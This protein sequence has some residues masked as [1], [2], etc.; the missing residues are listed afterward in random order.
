MVSRPAFDA[1][2]FVGRI[3]PK[4]WNRLL[5]D[6]D[7]PL[8]NRAIQA[9]LA[10]GSTF[11]PILALAA[12]ELGAIDEN[13]TVNC[14][15]SAM[16]YG[17]PFKCHK[18]HGATSLHKAI[19]QSCD[20]FFYA[21]G[22]KVGIDGIAK[23]GEMAG[24]GRKTG[25]DLPQEKEGELPSSSWKIRKFREKWYAG[26]TISVAIGQG[27]LTLTPI[28]LAQAI[29]GIATGGIWMKPHLV[30]DTAPT[31]PSRREDLNLDNV[32]KVVSGMYGVVNEWGTAAA[33][34]IPSISICGKT[35]TSQTAS[36]DYIKAMRAKG[37]SIKDNAW[38]VSFAPR[39]SPEIVVAVL[40]EEGLHGNL[41]APIAR[42]VIKAYF[43]KK[44]RKAAP[45]SIAN[46]FGFRP[47]AGPLR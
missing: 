22:N 13:F 7:K 42:D 12:L 4:E 6:P 8:I 35:G 25:I 24:L 29:G 47:P 32:S 39:E 43:D 21:V 3:D 40:F 44:V 1:N 28:Q 41:A 5:T 27:Y 31:E 11:K 19:V 18:V 36:L 10:P 33:A 17:R 15:G 38:F 20:V 23:Y 26:E 30:K 2:H 37:I 34:Q 16:W 46:S 45:P 14:G 9:Q